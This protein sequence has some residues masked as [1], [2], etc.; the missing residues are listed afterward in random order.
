MLHTKLSI[1][2]TSYLTAAYLRVMKNN[3][4]NKVMNST[5]K[6]HTESFFRPDIYLKTVRDYITFV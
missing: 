6:T 5:R 4:G 2:L 3:S 1:S